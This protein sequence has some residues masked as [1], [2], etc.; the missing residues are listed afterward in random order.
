M[1]LFLVQSGE[2][3]HRDG[4]GVAAGQRLARVRPGPRGGMVQQLAQSVNNSFVAESGQRVDDRQPYPFVGVICPGNQRWDRAGVAHATQDVGR[5]PE[6]AP[7]LIGE[8]GN[9]K[10]VGIRHASQRIE[11]EC[12]GPDCLRR[13][14]IFQDQLR[15]IQAGQTA[16]ASTVR[17][18]SSVTRYACS[19]KACKHRAGQ[20]AAERDTVSAPHIFRH[21]GEETKNSLAL[22]STSSQAPRRTEVLDQL[23]QL[24]EGLLP[25]G[26]WYGSIG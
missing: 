20:D 11:Q 21:S 15:G 26:R 3:R 10:R 13:T 17:V 6:I 4:A 19:I 2:E 16:T 9:D 7:A 23:Q 22:C 14:K 24:T 12:S 1:I 5:E 8:Q 18:C 25:G